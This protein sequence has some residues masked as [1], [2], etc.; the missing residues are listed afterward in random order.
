MRFIGI[1][2]GSSYVK[3][4]VL[5][6][7]SFAIEGVE[8]VES[9]APV[10]GLP[11]AFREVE[12]ERFVE[13]A[14][15]LLARLHDRARDAAGVLVSGQ[16]HGLVVC[17]A[18]THPLT[19]CITWQDTRALLPLPDSGRLCLAEIEELVGPADRLRLGNERVPGYPVNALHWLARHGRLPEG[20]VPLP[21][22]AYVAARLCGSP[23]ACDVT[24]AYGLGALDIESLDWH[25]PVIE[26]L[27]LGGLRWPRIVSQG[28]V[29]GHW[30]HGGGSLPVH[31]PVGDYHAAQVGALLTA[32]ELS[33]N[34]STGS[35]VA[36][37][38][39]SGGGDCQTR[40]WF[41]G[42][43]LA[44]VTHIPAGRAVAALIGLLGELAAAEGLELRDPW[45]TVIDRAER[46]ADAGGLE[47]D[48]AFYAGSMGDRGRIMNLREE[49]MTVGH[50]FHGVFAGMADN[51]GRAAA[52]VSPGGGWRRVVFSGGLATKVPL[53]RRLILERLVPDHRLAPVEEDTLF[54]LLVLARGFSTPEGGVAVAITAAREACGIRA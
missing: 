26:R 14:G 21:L 19:R 18:A 24:H 36:R 51:Y 37:I 22:P 27:G 43:Y 16:L 8:R 15:G 47:V 4:G 34:V 2:L 46:V 29:V 28:A 20:A 41:D 13:A 3:G 12:P 50:L 49:N 38:A 23:P 39:A 32:D 10:A 31:A 53:L 1:D 11:P 48:P 54:G 42:R 6:T 25:R 33:V 52:R 17:D 30:E 7:D 40:P 35:A 9:P 5:D 44:T 45:A